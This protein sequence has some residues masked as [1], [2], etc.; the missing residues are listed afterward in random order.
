MPVGDRE[1]FGAHL[2]DVIGLQLGAAGR[3]FVHQGSA[4]D[5]CYV[6]HVAASEEAYAPID[7]TPTGFRRDRLGGFA[8][9]G[10]ARRSW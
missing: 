5:A 7:Q 2:R 9:G 6:C 10:L 8:G 1:A 3:L 4:D